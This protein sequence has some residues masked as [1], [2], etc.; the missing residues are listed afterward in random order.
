MGTVG[1]LES[2]V[3]HAVKG[4]EDVMNVRLVTRVMGRAVC[5]VHLMNAVL[6][7]QQHNHLFQDVFHVQMT[8]LNANHVLKI[9]NFIQ[10]GDVLHVQQMNVV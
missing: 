5:H 10:Q 8:K 9:T 6:I 1:I 7:T 4:R 2:I 3:I